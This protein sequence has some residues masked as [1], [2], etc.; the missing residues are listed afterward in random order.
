[1]VAKVTTSI[2][3]EGEFGAAIKHVTI[4][5]SAWSTRW[6]GRPSFFRLHFSMNYTLLCTSTHTYEMNDYTRNA[7]G[8]VYMHTLL[9]FIHMHVEIIN[10]TVSAAKINKNCKRDK[11]W[12]WS[13]KGESYPPTRRRR[14]CAVLIYELR[15][16][17]PNPTSV[18][19]GLSLV[20]YTLH[21]LI[22]TAT[23]FHNENNRFKFQYWPLSS[24]EIKWTSAAA[25]R[26]YHHVVWHFF[27]S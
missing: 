19:V 18:D 23:L 4:I 6:K 24:S 20:L 9:F 14:V 25:A 17:I 5:N 1:M 22:K 15:R 27:F 21:W 11:L 7:R 12:W 16:T 26:H 8:K 10:E 2:A 13:F 3:A